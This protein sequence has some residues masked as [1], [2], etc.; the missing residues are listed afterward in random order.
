[1]IILLGASGYIGT[2]FEATLRK[3]GLAFLSVSRARCDYTRAEPLRDLLLTCKPELVI[4]S[5]GYTGKPN[6]DACETNRLATLEG[7]VLFPQRLSIVCAELKI[8]LGHVSS[9]CIFTGCHVWGKDGWRIHTN[10]N[11]PEV[12]KA[13]QVS[14]SLLRGYTEDTSPNFTFE[15]QSSFY[16][17]TKA[18]GELKVMAQGDNYVWRLRMPFDEE[19]HSRNYLT[20]LQTYA[21]VYNSLNSLSH[22]MEFANSCIDSWKKRIPFGIYNMT[23]PGFVSTQ[24]VVAMICARLKPRRSFI[25]WK[26]DAEFYQYGAVAP[27][28]NCIL[29]TSKLTRAGVYVRTVHEALAESLRN[30]R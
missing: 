3:K 15:N 7:N 25:F 18:L 1:M 4:N 16:S 6:V 27:R 5:A 13:A 30:W 20:K 21:K 19:D 22:R 14:P 10:I 12:R 28:S 17:G 9:G 11:S 29:E 24:E 26:D 2:A 23:N 8:P